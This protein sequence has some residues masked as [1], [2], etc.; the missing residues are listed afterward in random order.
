M[1]QTSEKSYDDDHFKDHLVVRHPDGRSEKFPAPEIEGAVTRIGRELDNDIVLVDPRASRHHAEVRQTAA[2]VLEIKDLNSAN[3]VVI[4]QNRLE[5]DVWHKMAPG[6]IVQLAETRIIWEKA[7]S[8]QS[9][10]AMTRQSLPPTATAAPAP[11]A[12]VE[13]PTTSMMPW[14]CWWSVLL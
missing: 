11:P 9:T 3:G 7:V 5:P 6:Q 1:T 14:V 12:V 13:R 10:V 4:N 8:S 2:G